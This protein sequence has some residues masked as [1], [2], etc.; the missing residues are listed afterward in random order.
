[1]D[2]ATLAIAATVGSSAIQGIGAIQSSQAA[3]ASAGYNAKVAGQNAQLA[4]QNAS[5]AGA[6][7][8]QEVGIQGAKNKAQI[9][10]ITANQGASGVDVNTGSSVNVRQSAAE[11]GMLN[12]LNIRSNAAKSAY[13]YQVQSA[14]DTAQ[15]ALYRSQQ[16]ADKTAGYLNAG[17]D[18][19]GGAGKAAMF[20]ATPGFQSYLNSTGTVG[21]LSG[22][23]PN[24][25]QLPWQEP[26]WGAG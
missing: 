16:S 7:G 2:P 22:M 3:A 13:G 26:G 17:A 4:T 10:A 1:M 8:E 11:V 12:A 18:I 23:G 14:S 20:A 15:A 5:F 24:Q 9:G 21:D 19:L 25:T 6:Q